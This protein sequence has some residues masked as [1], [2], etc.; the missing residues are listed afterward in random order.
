MKSSR[1]KSILI[2]AL[3][4]CCAQIASAFYDPNVQRWI[5]RDPVADPGFQLFAQTRKRFD[6]SL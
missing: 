1:T 5:N 3:T 2:A 4:L 6:E